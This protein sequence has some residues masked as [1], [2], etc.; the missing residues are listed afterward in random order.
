MGNLIRSYI[1]MFFLVKG[2][3]HGDLKYLLPKL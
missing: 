2:Q 3:A 1:Y